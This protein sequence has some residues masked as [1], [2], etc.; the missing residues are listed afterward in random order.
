MKADYC[1]PEQR[2]FTSAQMRT[3]EMS[4]RIAPLSVNSHY[5]H[6]HH[7]GAPRFSTT[8]QDF[9]RPDRMPGS[10]RLSAR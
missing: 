1:P 3:I 10:P 4:K 9:V 6:K 2:R 8:A 5:F 7:S